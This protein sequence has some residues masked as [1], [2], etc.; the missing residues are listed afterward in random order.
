MRWRVFL[1]LLLIFSGCTHKQVDCIHEVLMERQDDHPYWLLYGGVE[2]PCV[3]VS[4]SV[5]TTT[6]QE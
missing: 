3:K 4:P 2:I 1:F 5:E 6:H